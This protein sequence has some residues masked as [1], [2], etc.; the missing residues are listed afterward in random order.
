MYRREIQ[1]LLNDL[2]WVDDINYYHSLRTA[3]YMSRFAE[4]EAGKQFLKQAWV[5]RNEFVAIGLLHDI[6]KVRWP[7]EIL[8]A[9]ER[10]RNLGRE[11]VLQA[12][13]Y[14]IEHPLGSEEIILE[15]YK[16]TGNRFWERI[17]QGVVAHH[18]NY[19]GDGYPLRL[20]GSE[21]PL[22][23]R[24]LRLFDY[25]TS[26]TEVRRHSKYP[27]RPQEV[28]KFMRKGLGTYFDPYWGESIIDFLTNVQPPQNLDQWYEE[29]L[30]H[31]L[32]S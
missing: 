12:W 9:S 7:R 16:K 4:V 10:L 20:K 2:A 24:G 25:F 22:S 31:F 30:E 14:I 29:E 13:N 27:E 28:L 3:Y 8:L 21:I 5:T 26:A 32:I 11:R 23:A 18:E 17:A 1:Q 19:A 6:G 15:Y